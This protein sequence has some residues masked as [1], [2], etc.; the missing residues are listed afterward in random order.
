MMRY[1]KLLLGDLIERMKKF[2]LFLPFIPLK[3]YTVYAEKSCSYIITI[4]NIIKIKLT[5]SSYQ[6]YIPGYLIL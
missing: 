4:R 1:Q 5:D 6:S 3:R 2:C